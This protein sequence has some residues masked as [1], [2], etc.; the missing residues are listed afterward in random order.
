M[1]NDKERDQFS[2]SI[3]VRVQS[4]SYL[5]HA[6]AI[7]NTLGLPYVHGFRQALDIGIR[8]MVKKHGKAEDEAALKA[9]LEAMDKS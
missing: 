1:A 5:K 6:H 8:A 9:H 7:W 4:T 2:T 3:G